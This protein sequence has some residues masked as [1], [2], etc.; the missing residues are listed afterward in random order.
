MNIVFIYLFTCLTHSSHEKI[1][2]KSSFLSI[3]NKHA[4]LRT[5]RVRTRSSP[6]ITSELEKRMHDRNI[7][8]IKASKSND[9][10]DW[11]LFKNNA[12]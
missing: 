5:M 3:V 7:L 6:W 9:S 1:D 8:K 10:N 2:V 4:P 11:S 12:I